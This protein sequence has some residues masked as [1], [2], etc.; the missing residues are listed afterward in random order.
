MES[1]DDEFVTR[2]LEAGGWPARHSLWNGGYQVVCTSDKGELAVEISA[3]VTVI[4]PQR[5][6]P[7]PL[8]KRCAAL[9]A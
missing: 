2:V 9:E 1:G 8:A 7:N 4:A 6:Y 3:H 5:A